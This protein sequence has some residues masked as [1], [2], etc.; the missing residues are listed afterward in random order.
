MPGCSLATS[1]LERREGRARRSSRSCGGAE[2][3]RTWVAERRRVGAIASAR[4]GRPNATAG[5]SRDAALRRPSRLQ[6]PSLESS[7]RRRD[8][9]LEVLPEPDGIPRRARPAW[10]GSRVAAG[11]GSGAVPDVGVSPGVCSAASSVAN[12]PG[13]HGW[14]R[15]PC[16]RATPIEAG[17]GVEST[18]AGDLAVRGECERGGVSVR[19]RLSAPSATD[20]RV[21]VA[22]DG[23]FLLR[24]R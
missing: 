8:S 22:A 9:A 1:R 5:L 21:P 13:G 23:T 3:L 16:A 15:D 14:D 2:R 18:S 20:A 12:D 19:D 4:R 10:F 6:S 24:T 17:K 7:E 11:G